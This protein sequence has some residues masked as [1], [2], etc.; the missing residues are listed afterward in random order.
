MT[1]KTIIKNKEEKENLREKMFI[2]NDYIFIRDFY[3][4]SLKKREKIVEEIRNNDLEIFLPKKEDFILA[5]PRFVF[6]KGEVRDLSSL[7]GKILNYENLRKEKKI[8]KYRKKMVRKYPDK[9]DLQ[10]LFK[11]TRKFADFINLNKESIINLLLNYETYE[12][13]SDEV[14]RTLDL[15]YNISENKEYFKRAAGEVTVFMPRNQPLYAF[16]CFVLVPSLM[17]KSVHTKPPVAMEYFFF[18]LLR[19]LRIEYFFSNVIIHKEE[20]REDFLQKRAGTFGKN[21]EPLTDAVIFTGTT[22][23]AQK[24]RNIFDRKTLFIANG[25]GHNPVVVSSDAD[26]KKAIKSVLK[27][28]LY[29]QGQDCAAP[30]SIL[31]HKKNYKEFIYELKRSLKKVKF[32]ECK[33]RRVRV[34]PIRSSKDFKRVIDFLVSNNEWLDSDFGGKVH[35]NSKIIEPVI[36]SKPLTKGGNFTE[37]FAPIFFIQCYN[38]DSDL[39]LYFETS[40]Y[41]KNAMFVT[42]F[43]RSK[44]VD[45][46]LSKKLFGGRVLHNQYTI[47]RNTNLHA[48]G[49]ERGTQQYGGFGIG[50]SSYSIFGEVTPCPT[51]PQRDIYEQLVLPTIDFNSKQKLLKENKIKKDQFSD[52]IYAKRIKDEKTMNKKNLNNLEKHWSSV[53]ADKVLTDFPDK[54]IYTCAAGISPSGVI[55]FGNFRDIM[56]SFAVL[57]Q[58]EKRGKNVRF[59]FSWDDFDRLRKIPKNIPED[60]KKYI[61]LPLSSV[62][63]PLGEYSSYAERFEKEFENSMKKLGINLDYRYQT[64]EYKKGRYDDFIIKA[65][66]KRKEIAEILLSF[67]SG[68]AKKKKNIDPKEFKEEYYPVHLYSR[69]NNKDNTKIIDYDGESCITY[70]CLETGKKDKVDLRKERVCKL[71]WK[72][73]WAMRW[74]AEDVVFEPGGQDH[75]APGS[76][77]DTSTNIAKKIFGGEPPVFTGYQ[78]VGLKGISGKMSGSKGNAVSP[79]QLLEIY[80]S[81]ILKWLYLRKKP[82]AVFNLAFDDEIYRQYSEFDKEVDDYVRGDIGQVRKDSLKLAGINKNN[83]YKNPISFREMV[84]LG[85]ITQWNLEK[86]IKLVRSLKLGYDENSIKDRIEKAKTWLEIYNPQDLISLRKEKNKD[87]ISEM[88]EESIER[89]R[90]MRE[91][92]INNPF[93]IEEIEKAMYEIPK[94]KNLSKKENISQQRKFFKDLYNLLISRNNGPRISTFLWAA[95]KKKVLE[96]LDI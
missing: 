23:N 93:S 72:T 59:I 9:I 95:N 40:E 24:L 13:A 18:D 22:E 19:L 73:D 7:F 42:L 82:K 90:K 46:L 39:K 91:V 69:F 61:G 12:V 21:R 77:Y 51:L 38:K 8:E 34:G 47:I 4:L 88:S 55:H 85:Q 49:V 80:N 14:E 84:S 36:I 25:S 52:I 78:F 43:G 83:C 58:L 57:K 35:I 54:K 62:P 79:N 2:K 27:I 86:I 60:F 41:S 20:I 68:K 81:T 70:E 16:S 75:S 64:G 44:Y 26:L 53:I 74:I 48:P 31:V 65:L 28:Q 92:L 33:D 67:M 6:E 32:G 5:I 87:Y 71:A 45:S 3:K 29:N 89:I 15:F 11:R 1:T 96:L 10:K 17:C 66:Q 76:S 50:S 37:Q 63:D 56:T 30:N 94:G